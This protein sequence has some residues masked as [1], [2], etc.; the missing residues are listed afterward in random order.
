MSYIDVCSYCGA[1]R[2]QKAG[3]PSQ[4]CSPACKS[5]GE[6]EI[7]RLGNVLGKLELGRAEDRLNDRPTERRDVALSEVRARLDRLYGVQRPDGPDILP[8]HHAIP[9]GER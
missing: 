2:N 3:R 8:G 7:R 6:A 4:W 5:A 9:G 1:H